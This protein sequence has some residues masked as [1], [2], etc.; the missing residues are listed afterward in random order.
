MLVAKVADRG[1]VV[2]RRDDHAALFR[3]DGEHPRAETRR[4]VA[5]AEVRGREDPVD[6]AVGD[7]ADGE[8]GGLE[9]IGDGAGERAP[10]GRGELATRCARVSACP[11]LGRRCS[12]VLYQLDFVIPG[13]APWCAS[14]RRQMRQSPNFR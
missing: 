9:A 11:R 8:V 2:V 4:E 14:S 7:P 3:E 12:S 6:A 13:T 10:V 1:E 5:G